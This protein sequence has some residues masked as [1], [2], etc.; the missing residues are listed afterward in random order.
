MCHHGMLLLLDC[1]AAVDA[2]TGNVEAPDQ[3]IITRTSHLSTEGMMDEYR[4]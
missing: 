3:P 4:P 1:G 2:L